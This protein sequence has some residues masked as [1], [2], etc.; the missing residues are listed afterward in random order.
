MAL[1]Y[2][3]E[4]LESV[5]VAVWKI[6]ESEEELL[7]IATDLLH[8]AHFLELKSPVRRLEWLASRILARKVLG[9]HVRI[10][11]QANNKPYLDD[12]NIHLSLSHAKGYAGIAF[13]PFP[14]GLDLEWIDGRAAR[15]SPRFMNAWEMELCH[16]EFPENHEYIKTRIW[17][18]K[19][20]V[21]KLFSKQGVLFKEQIITQKFT[22]YGAKGY[23]HHQNEKHNYEAKFGV[24]APGLLLTV[25]TNLL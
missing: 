18:L 1:I 3:Q 17:S 5:Q 20:A 22:D 9:K 23:L 24:V 4:F 2:K 19:E 13:A 14:V 16:P 6:E 10:L 7:D 15:I 21:F 8:N 25:A 12:L 11:K